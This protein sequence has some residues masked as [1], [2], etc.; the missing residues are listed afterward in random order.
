M[1]NLN[2]KASK[3]ALFIHALVHYSHALPQLPESRAK[4]YQLKKIKIYRQLLQPRYNLINMNVGE[5]S[6]MFQ[7]DLSL[8]AIPQFKRG[9]YEELMNQRFSRR[10]ERTTEKSLNSWG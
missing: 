8:A 6:N 2:N 7:P 10:R 1:P 5:S 4:R 9:T 3:Q